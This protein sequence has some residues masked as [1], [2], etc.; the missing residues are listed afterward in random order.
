ML[1]IYY[2]YNFLTTGEVLYNSAIYFGSWD[3]VQ[4]YGYLCSGTE[5]SLGNCNYN[6]RYNCYAY[7]QAGVRCTGYT[8][9]STCSQ[10]GDIRL[11]GGSNE[12]EGVLEYCY[13]GYWSPLC[14]VDDEEA[15]VACRQLG[16]Y[17]YTCGSLSKS[18]SL[19]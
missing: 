3:Y 6:Y 17:Q 5:L 10:D 18:H 16:H 13:L 12:N 14:S 9:K 4:N 15:T 11:S 7:N 8:L 1:T 19:V 2:L